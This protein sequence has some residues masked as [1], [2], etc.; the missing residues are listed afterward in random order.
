MQEIRVIRADEAEALAY[1]KAAAFAIPNTP[2]NFAPITREC[3][4]AYEAGK[5]CASIVIHPHE[6]RWCGSYL[7]IFGLGG[8]MTLPLARR[9]GLIRKLLAELDRISM[10]RGL[11]YGLL[12]PFSFSYYRQFGY[13]RILPRISLTIPFEKL[14][15]VPRNSDAIIYDGSQKDALFALYHRY[16]DM[17][18]LMT[19]A[20]ASNYNEEPELDM[21]YTYIHHSGAEYDA[22]INLHYSGASDLITVDELVYTTPASLLGILGV[23]RLFEGQR[24]AVCFSNLPPT[25]PVVNLLGHYTHV[26]RGFN[27]GAMG[28]ILD[29]ETLLRRNTYPMSPGHFTLTV[30]DTHPGCAGTFAVEYENGNVDVRRVIGAA[31]VETDAPNLARILLSGEGYGVEELAF[32]PGTMVSNMTRAEDFTRAFPRRMTDLFTHFIR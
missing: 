7:P 21:R 11:V 13:E 24:R 16:A 25:S 14:D 20:P 29:T 9:N 12:Y 4:G 5:L 6:S 30:H 15:C 32:M 2:A 18:N 10:E 26:T 8:V 23:L 27:N 19:R 31:D 28:R 3:L 22:Y 1:L 17:H